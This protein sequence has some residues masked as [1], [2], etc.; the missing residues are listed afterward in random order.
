M[1]PII[2]GALIGAAAETL[3]SAASSAVGYNSSQKQMAFQERMSN[4]AHQREVADLR[5]AGL[6]PILSATGGH[7]ASSPVG[8]MFTPDNP[9]KGVSNTVINGMLAKSTVGLNQEQIK[10]IN[11][12]TKTQLTQ[13]ILN[14][15][16]AAKQVADA[17]LTSKQLD[18]I[19]P[20]IDK[21]RQ[22][23]STSSAVEQKTN[24]EKK[25]AHAQALREGAKTSFY[26]EGNSPTAKYSGWLKEIMNLVNP[27]AK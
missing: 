19:A 16:T 14:S 24:E 17:A 18:L 25:I 8:A 27:F 12:Q 6:N 11:E 20:Q 1:D 10:N 13:Q 21:L 15:A 26:D 23:T 22:E 3:G 4:T 5:A 7:G 2:G 9:L